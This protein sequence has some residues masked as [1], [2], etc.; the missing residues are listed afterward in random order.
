ME[1][2]SHQKLSDIIKETSPD[3][4][5]IDMFILLYEYSNGSLNHSDNY[6]LCFGMFHD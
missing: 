1:L 5:H 3:I 4:S 2:L 6:T